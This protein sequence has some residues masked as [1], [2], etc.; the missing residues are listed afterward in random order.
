MVIIRKLLHY[1]MFCLLGYIA[2]YSVE[3]RPTFRRNISPPSSEMANKPT[4]NPSESMWQAESFHA[5]FLLDLLFDP[6]DGDKMFFRNV[7]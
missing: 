3:N 2:M 1:E 7:G 4:R 6:E 5:G